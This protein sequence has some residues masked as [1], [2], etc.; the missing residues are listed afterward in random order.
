MSKLIK[1]ADVIEFERFMSLLRDKEVIVYEDVQGSKIWVNYDGRDWNIR[2]RS[3]SEK[4][5]NM[6]DLAIQ[7]LYNHAYLFFNSMS[8]N[9]AD[10]LKKDWWFGFEYFGDEQPAHVKYSRLPK[11]RLV[12]TAII[13]GKKGFTNNIDDLVA[14]SGVF[15]CDIRPVL[16]RGKLSEKQIQLINRFLHTSPK[17]LEFVFDEENF[18]SFFYKMLNPLKKGSFLME[19][20]FQDNLESIIIRF[21]DKGEEIS[22]ELLNPLYNRVSA[23]Q[24]TDY[25]DVYSMVLM[26]F[27]QF[28]SSM[29]I[30]L[31][32]VDGKTFE[33]TYINM[34][35]KLYNL[36]M[37]KRFNRVDSLD[38]V[39]P[40]FYSYDKFRLNKEMI[41]N[42]NTLEWITENDKF[43]YI[44]RILLTTLRK[45]IKKPFGVFTERTIG[46][47]NK[48]VRDVNDQVTWLTSRGL[49]QS[50]VVE[51]PGNME[52]MTPDA[53]ISGKV[54]L[55]DVGS[56]APKKNKMLKL[57]KLL[58]K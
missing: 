20:E 43:E 15:D 41:K 28:M 56:T 18:C 44:L 54:F 34:V 3:V 50:S 58:K 42:H 40:E 22:L 11:N 21:S 2:P 9:R 19:S 23:P 36:Y 26:D 4:N 52:W 29:D 6:V 25:T 24:Y 10:L 51:V 53:D 49:Q 1:S 17:D 55:N 57:S 8:P 12:L 47:F 7:K 46:M 37:L 38:L 33:T 5:I 14:M 13:R 45:Q 32:K 27:M 39:V 31:V 30:R 16:F 35:C 48:V